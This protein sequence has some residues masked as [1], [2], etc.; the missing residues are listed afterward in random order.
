MDLLFVGFLLFWLWALYDV[1]TVDQHRVR[2]LPKILWIGI[3]VV[4]FVLGALLWVFL[5]RPPRDMR[6]SHPQAPRRPRH[7]AAPP[8]PESPR[9]AAQRVV[10]DRRSAELDRMLD[11][12]ERGRRDQGASES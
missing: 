10:T 1:I 12:W 11:E 8:E 4:L 9:D 7:R 5:G 3:T 6:A 2:N